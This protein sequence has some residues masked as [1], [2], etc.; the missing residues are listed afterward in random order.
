MSTQPLFR[1]PDHL[2]EPQKV[3]EYW[4]LVTALLPRTTQ[5]LCAVVASMLSR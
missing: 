1:E 5:S 2:E 4:D 3:Q